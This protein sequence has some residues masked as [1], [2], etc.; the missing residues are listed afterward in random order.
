MEVLEVFS[1]SKGLAFHMGADKKATGKRTNQFDQNRT[2]LG[3]FVEEAKV[4]QPELSCLR[5]CRTIN[6]SHRK[7]PC[8][9]LEGTA[10]KRLPE[11]ER[12]VLR[13]LNETNLAGE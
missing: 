5:Q 10:T 11:M 3:A 1:R 9:D 12:P 13:N 6:D 7:S 2:N 4:Y 8:R